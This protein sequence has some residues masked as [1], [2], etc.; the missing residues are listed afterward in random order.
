MA[1]GRRGR[2]SSIDMLPEEAQPDVQWAIGE[3]NARKR[4]AESIRLELNE[5]LLAL[6]AAPVSA[7]A[8]NRYSLFIARHGQAMQQ[9]RGIAALLAEKMDEEPDGDVGLLLAE[10]IKTMIYDVMM[11]EA[12]SEAPSMKMLLAAAEAVQRL[13]LARSTSLKA[14]AFKRERFIEKAAEM[15]ETVEAIKSAILGVPK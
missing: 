2:L 5:R 7:S 12:L 11:N 15:A 4:T 3:L 1:T 13:E 8:F 14:A 9:V 10:T 6:G